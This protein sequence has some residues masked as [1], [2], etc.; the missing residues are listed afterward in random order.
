MEV[1]DADILRAR[2]KSTEQSIE[3]LTRQLTLLRAQQ[4]SIDIELSKIVYPVLLLPTEIISAVFRAATI[5][6]ASASDPYDLVPLL[7]AISGV[8][9]LWRQIA[10]SDPTLWTNLVFN[11]GFVEPGELFKCFVSRSAGLPIDVA[12]FL[13][14]PTDLETD[15]WTSAHQWRRAKFLGADHP[16]PFPIEYWDSGPLTLPFLEELTLDV[17]PVDEAAGEAMFSVVPRLTTLRISY[18]TLVAELA[19]PADQLTKVELLRPQYTT[20]IAELL[21]SLV[22]LEELTVGNVLYE[23]ALVAPIVSAP[24]LHTVICQGSEWQPAVVLLQHLTLPALHTLHLTHVPFPMDYVDAFL[25]RSGPLKKLT[26]R[27]AGFQT[28][29]AFFDSP[30]VQDVVD[31]V[32]EPGPMSTGEEH[33]VRAALREGALPKLRS[34]AL[35]LPSSLLADR[36]IDVQAYISAVHGRV[37]DFRPLEEF[38]LNFATKSWEVPKVDVGSLR[39]LKDEFGLRINLPSGILVKQKVAGLE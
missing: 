2:K 9:R 32:L 11:Y 25:A 24:R 12:A 13:P 27:N 7:L 14:Y 20:A 15:L 4:A 21:P 22:N 10:I 34:F 6:T 26:L 37:R 36:A 16:I 29:M 39:R 38:T 33:R 17:D 5:G 31:F 3:E 30:Y 23:E 1:T 18:L 35:D 8:C 28:T 19:F